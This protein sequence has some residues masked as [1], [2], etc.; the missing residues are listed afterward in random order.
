MLPSFRLRVRCV[1]SHHGHVELCVWF[2]ARGAVDAR[3]SASGSVVGPAF[4]P[5]S[6]SAVG[7]ALGRGPRTARGVLDE[8]ALAADLPGESTLTPR[9]PATHLVDGPAAAAPEAVAPAGAASVAVASVTVASVAVAS[10]SEATSTVPVVPRCP[11]RRQ[12]GPLVPRGAPSLRP[13]QEAADEQSDG[14]VGSR[15]GGGAGAGGSSGGRGGGAGALSVRAAVEASAALL[16]GRHDCFVHGLACG[17]A[18]AR[19]ALPVARA[20]ATAH[21]APPAGLEAAPPCYMASPVAPPAAPEMAPVATPG[22][23]LDFAAP[24]ECAL[25]R[26]V[27]TGLPVRLVAEFAFGNLDH[28]RCALTRLRALVALARG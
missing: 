25:G 28:L 19:A 17:L 21:V 13:A 7:P 6:E 16:L 5:A 22:S 4:G 11:R 15:S 14:G 9:R 12:S 2:I 24:A 10:A 27:G 18:S 20:L 23:A 8:G 1:C 26:L 3:A